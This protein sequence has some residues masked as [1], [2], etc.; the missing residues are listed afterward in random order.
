MSARDDFNSGARSPGGWGGQGN[1][2]TQAGAGGHGSLGG[3][4]GSNASGM[5]GLL[6]VGG[7]FGSNTG[8]RSAGGGLTGTMNRGG[9]AMEQLNAR[10]GP[11]GGKGSGG[12][13]SVRGFPQ[14]T[15]QQY[16]GGWAGH[17][18]RKSIP[19]VQEPVVAPPPGVDMPPGFDAD[20]FPIRPPGPMGA[21][22]WNPSGSNVVWPSSPSSPG[23][24]TG[25]GPAQTPG[26]IYPNPGGG[27]NPGA[28]GGNGVDQ[29]QYKNGQWR[30]PMDNGIGQSG[31]GS[32]G[33]A[34]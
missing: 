20:G 4:S 25:T 7:G 17:V 24:H 15:R 13:G 11:V 33:G 9:S 34:K 32:Y 28:L 27:Y 8:N 14:Y 6:G 1:M 3:G 16:P 10:F 30:G 2:N 19:G 18:F 29:V 5:G 12:M 21:P 23:Y 31:W 22:G 26:A